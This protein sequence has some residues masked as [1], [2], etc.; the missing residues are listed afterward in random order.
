MNLQS[1][2]NDNLESRL[3]KL[4]RTE[5]KITHLVLQCIAE[6]D[7]RELYIQKA[8]P[9][10]F[11][12]LVQNY[13]YSP[14][15]AMRRIDGARLLQQIPEVAEQI[16]NGKVNLSQ[17]SLL[18][19]AEREIKRETKMAIPLE[20]KK[21]HLASMEHQTQ[22][23]TERLIAQT[24]NIDINPK[25]KVTQHKD[26]SVTLTMTL[27]KEQMKV[28]EQAEA[29]LSHAVPEKNWASLIAY[30]AKNE[31]S[32][33]TR[34][35]VKTSEVSKARNTVDTATVSKPAIT[36]RAN[37]L[38]SI[39]KN[40]IGV[41]VNGVLSRQPIPQSVKKR[42]LHTNALCSYR[43]PLTGKICNSRHFLQIDHIKSVSRG[44]GNELTNLQVLCGRHNRF[45]FKLENR[46]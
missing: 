26:E 5:R 33:R 1:L 36:K 13:G 3:K 44:G 7:R 21:E 29:M 41:G 19:R 14:S 9:S 25:N 22:V 42:V 17:V 20:I 16:K 24:L 2:S 40:T 38:T 39:Y 4:V 15:A 37:Q 46:C 8:Y 32:R 12:F 43:D 35:I 45:K 34:K 18:Q 6:I 28:L 31:L 30:L 27:T 10:L 23:R 11:E